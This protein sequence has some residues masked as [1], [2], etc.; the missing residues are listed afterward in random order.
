MLACL[1]AVWSYLFR[2]HITLLPF[3]V[4]MVIRFLFCTRVTH[5]SRDCPPQN[6]FCSV[7][8]LFRCYTHA[9]ISVYAYCNNS[10]SV[11]YEQQVPITLTIII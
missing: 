3:P 11:P 10:G 2:H 8:V 9:Y 7:V 5:M 1:V 4:C 6:T